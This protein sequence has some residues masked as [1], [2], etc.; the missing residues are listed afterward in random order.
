MRIEYKGTV[1]EARNVQKRTFSTEGM[2]ERVNRAN[3]NVI[4]RGNLW[5]NIKKDI[6]SPHTLQKIIGALGVWG[7]PL[8]QIEGAVAN[9]SLLL[10]GSSIAGAPNP[11]SDA[12]STTTWGVLRE[13]D[14]KIRE[15]LIAGLTGRKQGEYGDVL[16]VAGVPRPLAAAGGVYM[17]AVPLMFYAALQQSLKVGIHK[18]SDA[19]GKRIGKMAADASDESMKHTS[20]VLNKGYSPVNN[21][22]VDKG[23]LLKALRE[24]PDDI[25]DD[26]L[27][28]IQKVFPGVETLDDIGPHLQNV[29]AARWIKKTMGEL[30]PG[31]F[32]K[33][34]TGAL[35]TIDVNRM[36]KGYSE[37]KNVIYDG[38]KKAKGTQYADDLLQLEAEAAE[39]IKHGNYVKNIVTHPKTK[40]PS[41]GAALVKRSSTEGETTARDA[42][43][44]MLQK[45]GPDAS[46]GIK[47]VMQDIAKFNRHLFWIQ[48][49]KRALSA[50]IFGGAAASVGGLL[51]REFIPKGEGID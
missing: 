20:G 12:K 19:T 18:I 32:G 11:Y 16:N 49:G 25:Q 8:K 30:D 50:A 2:Q 43:N 26:L 45:G 9:P 22:G 10:Q 46:K 4:K 28:E 24:F 1:E 37:L 44:I 27:R 51:L 29:K 23:K 42:L 17:N 34:K 48:T 7:S 41:R 3:T 5:G 13:G 14:K 31:A 38:V 40:T 21:S 36:N 39:V 6:K 47:V 33:G 35:K 15:E